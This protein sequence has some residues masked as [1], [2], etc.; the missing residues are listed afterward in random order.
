LAH[1]AAALG[2]RL[3]GNG[4]RIGLLGGSFNPAHGGHREISTAALRHLNLDAVW[5]LV[6][7][8]NPLK[9]KAGTA[10]LRRRLAAA[11]AAAHHPRIVVS[12]L[13]ET[14]GTN[15]T[16]DT[17]ATLVHRFP[18]VRFVWLM[19]ADNLIQIP[20]WRRWPEIFAAIAVAVFDRP[21]YSLK[22]LAAPAARRFARQRIA[23]GTAGS[24][25]ERDPP[26]WVFIRQRLNAQSSTRIRASKQNPATPGGKRRRGV[27][28]S[29]TKE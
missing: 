21:T 3:P 7:P 28:S 13:E 19:G 23:E 18:R 15:F 17:I 1:V 14:L 10:P 20:Q 6:A 9:A 4:Q 29:R 25:A 16:V 8:Q 5:W 27:K 26:A 22:A 12:A 2:G 11:A 24:L